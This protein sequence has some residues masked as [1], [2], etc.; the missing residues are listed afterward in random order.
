MRIFQVDAFTDQPFR[1][2][3]ACVCMPDGD[4]PDAWMQSVASEMN[5][6]ETAFVLK[7]KNG[8]DLRWF[9]PK[10]EV[11]LCGHATLA[12]AHILW[13]EGYVRAEEEIA[14]RTKSGQL[15]AK[16]DGDW[17]ELDFPAG[18]VASSE[19][20]PG[21]NKALGI[22]PR[23]TSK[24]SSS[25]GDLYLLEVESEEVVRAIAPDFAALSSSSARSVIVT[26]GSSTVGCDFVSRYF[27]PLVG[28]NEDPV[29][30]SAHCYLA[31]YWGTKLDKTTL[32]GLQ[33][34]ERTGVVGC[35]WRGDRV[36]L[37]G[38]AITIFRGE[39]LV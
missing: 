35:T 3:P 26:A 28:I 19:E 32:V 38:K 6:S 29:T 12:T 25:R 17:I 24:S 21:L 1:G 23:Y 5:L 18:A 27:A 8:F 9:T 33:V 39:L 11:S 13:E 37:R 10:R 7:G 4:R 20:N 22:T 16:R 31:P 36:I 34:S 2:N 14:F 30:G 15:G